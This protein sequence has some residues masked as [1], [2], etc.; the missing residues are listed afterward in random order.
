MSWTESA[1]GTVTR[2]CGSLNEN[3]SGNGTR[4]WSSRKVCWVTGEGRKVERQSHVKGS[5]LMEENRRESG[6]SSRRVSQGGFLPMERQ[7][8]SR[9][10]CPG[11]AHH[12][13]TETL[14]SNR[15]SPAVFGSK[16]H[17]L[18]LHR[19]EGL[20]ACLVCCLNLSL[21]HP[22]CIGLVQDGQSAC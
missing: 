16:C 18:P 12:E 3:E 9:G 20:E 19:I 21:A 15:W 13:R 11:L 14:G 10:P 1:C 6:G 4:Y 7:S 22:C 8:D 5:N 17:S 2:S